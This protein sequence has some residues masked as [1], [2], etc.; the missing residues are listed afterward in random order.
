MKEA[1]D[2]RALA[3]A[4]I[5]L[6]GNADN[7]IEVT[8]CITRLR[9]RLRDE[10]IADTETIESLPGVVKVLSSGGQYQVVIGA[11][12][13]VVYRALAAELHSG[14][15]S[16][17]DTRPMA[18]KPE[19]PAGE[20]K[21]EG[22]KPPSRKD[23]LRSAMGWLSGFLAACMQP[24]IPV[25][26]SVGLIRALSMVLGPSML[27]WLGADSGTFRVMSLIGDA[28]FAALPIFVAWSASNYLKTNTALALF[29]A[30]IL[31]GPDLAALI[32]SGEKVRLFALPVP[33]VTYASQVVPAMLVMA[34]MYGVERLLKKWLPKDARFIGLPM[35]ETLCML[36]LTLCAVGPLGAMLGSCVARAVIALQTAVGPLIVALIGACFLF[37]CAAGMHT[38]LLA[39]AFILIQYQGYDSVA[40]VGA[41]PAAYACFGIYLAYALLAGNGDARAAGANALSSH[42]VGGLAESAMFTV[43]YAH[44]PLMGIQIAS[45]FLGALYLGAKGVGMYTPGTSNCLAV[46]QYAGGTPDNLI[47]AALGCGISFLSGLT[48]TAVA[49]LWARNRM[50]HRK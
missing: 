6:V 50:E 20:A 29:Y 26:V 47:H 44:K 25:L 19:A 11:A 28:G 48:L 49:Q 24:L 22:Q 37:I 4:L 1:T 32:N 3:K 36:P 21:T 31:V 40:M 12:A 33:A 39:V 43:L 34:A 41:G 27:G 16:A 46:I 14:K 10:R 35:L 42:A 23:A 2:C 9:F 15:A 13:S 18:Q 8:H 38:A 5:P 17:P 30:A 7:I 45:A